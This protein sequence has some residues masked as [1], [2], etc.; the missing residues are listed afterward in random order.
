MLQYTVANYL[1]SYQTVSVRM[2]NYI[3][4][5]SDQTQQYNVKEISLAIQIT[6]TN[7]QK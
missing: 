1:L 3:Q 7:G 6:L 5:V 4:S 2:S